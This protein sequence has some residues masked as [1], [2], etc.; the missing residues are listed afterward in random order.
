MGD[1]G[2]AKRKWFLGV[3]LA[4]L[5]GAG[6]G[7]A[8]WQTVGPHS[9]SENPSEPSG[10][11]AT[12]GLPWFEDVTRAAGIDFVHF[13]PQTERHYIQET[14]GSGLG[15]IDYDN[16]GWLDLFC[17]QD[18]P[19]KPGSGPLPTSKLYRNNGDG[20]F[21]DVT[22]KVGLAR[23][24]FGMGCA[25]GDFDNDGYDDLVVT[26]LGGVVLFHNEP[27]GK[28]GRHFVDVTA[29]A[30][31]KDPHWA[32]SCAWGDLD[33]DGFL[34]L[35]VCNYCEVDLEKYPRCVT[36][37]G[38]FYT[39]QPF[40]FPAVTHQ[41][42]RNN[43]D[44]TFTDVS[45]ASGI[46]RVPPAPGLGVIVTDVDGDGRMDVYVANDLK[47]A[48]LFHNQGGGRFEERALFS[49]CG[50]GPAGRP[51]A[52]MGVEAGDLDGS[53]RPSLFVTNFQNEPNVVYRN[54]GNLL[55]TD[56]TTP[57][58]LG[59]P[60]I[61]RLGFGC[62]LVDVDLDG[63][64]DF[65]VANGHVNRN[66]Q[67]LYGALFAQEAQLFLGTA[68][69]RFRDVSSQAGTYFQTRVVGRGLAWADFDND[70]LPDLAFSH[71]GGPISLLRNRTATANA[72]LRLELI[73]DGIRSNRNAIG[74][75]IEVEAG[76]GKQVRFL[77]GGGSY[78]SASDRRLLIGLGSADRAARVIVTW[79]SGRVQTFTDLEGRTGWRLHEGR[80]NPERMKE[81]G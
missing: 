22:E 46:A 16:D 3:V 37:R 10:P 27:D 38:A 48:Y 30:G 79:P 47:P 77:N 2:R 13:D 41:L 20:T 5:L 49:G 35:Y 55:F 56:W 43:G 66:S 40:H 51:V 4:C 15:W 81:K 74:A 14:M 80:E 42:Y 31:I 71:N 57:S 19:I 29:R 8:L 65:A 45:E 32:T 26:Y 61:S 28:G 23:A 25:V 78:L 69:G 6:V 18:G 1:R 33:G 21:T 17:V 54:R 63:R 76:G 73:G 36:D 75:R 34:D 12:P 58:G 60:S 9:S 53:G 59:P 68:S 50:L 64:L 62:V 44:G 72:W 67:E 11:Q 52:G 39:C 24:G 7:L 70:G